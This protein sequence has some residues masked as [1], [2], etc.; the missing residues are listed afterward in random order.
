MIT[1]RQYDFQL[2]RF[3]YLFDFIILID[4]RANYK[5]YHHKKLCTKIEFINLKY[6]LNILSKVNSEN[7]KMIAT[8]DTSTSTT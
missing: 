3:I 8:W 1:E 7:Y 6:K 4:D 5:S 2:E